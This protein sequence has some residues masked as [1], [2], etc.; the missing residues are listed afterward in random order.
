MTLADRLKYIGTITRLPHISKA[1]YCTSYVHRT[2]KCTHHRRRD[3]STFDEDSTQ[4]K[5]HFLWSTHD[6]SAYLRAEPPH[7]FILYR[8]A[9]NS[10]GS[11]PAHDRSVP[12]PWAP[13]RPPHSYIPCAG[14]PCQGS[15]VFPPAS[16]PCCLVLRRTLPK[17]D[18]SILRLHLCGG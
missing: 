16:F 10:D 3:R 18:T 9:T 13:L 8:G 2:P 15:N 6:A 17:D 1:L 11:T 14:P 12:R 7:L 5:N 4:A